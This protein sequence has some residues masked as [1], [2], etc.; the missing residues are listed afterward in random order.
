[1]NSFDSLS[2]VL[3][4]HR[5]FDTSTVGPGI[6]AKKSYW[7]DTV[8]SIFYQ[9]DCDVGDSTTFDARAECWDLADIRLTRLKSSPTRYTRRRQDCDGRETQILVAVPMVGSVE[10]DQLGR[11][12]LPGQ[13]VLEYSDAPYNFQYG[14]ESDMLAVRI[15]ESML[16]SRARSAGAHGPARNDFEG[17]SWSGWQCR[18]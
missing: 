17:F 2:K 11:R 3:S 9:L 7:R 16:Q 15:P 1:M 8:S 18:R 10:L 4:M 13:F 12:C 14:A 6:E 5:E